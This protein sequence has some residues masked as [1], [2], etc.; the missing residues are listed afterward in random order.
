MKLVSFLHDG[1]R[2]VGLMLD[3]QRLVSVTKRLPELPD[4]IARILARDGALDEIRRLTDAKHEDFHTGQITFQPVI[5]QPQAIWCIGLNYM[6]HREETSHWGSAEPTIFMRMPVSQVAHG[7][8][9]VKPRVSEQLDYEGEL[10]VIIGKTGRHIPEADAFAYVGGYSCYNE[11]SVRD[12]QKHSP[13]Y[14]AGKNFYASGAFGPWM[15]TPDE[16]GSPDDNRI[17][18]KLNG[19]IVQDS[20]IDLMIFK[21]PKLINYLSTFYPLQ[22]GDVIATGTPAGVGARR[23]PQR[24]LRGGDRIEVTI[25]NIGTLS[26]PVVNEPAAPAHAAPAM[27]KA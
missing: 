9:I 20:S 5:P 15:V 17:T 1:T 26:N 10:A 8:P 7:H 11:G 14:G 4:T 12:W 16:F 21:I 22:P 23:N 27:A 13:Q 25:S 19:E 24:F 6:S 2:Q 18:T 3:E